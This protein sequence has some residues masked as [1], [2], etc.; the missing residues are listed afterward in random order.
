MRFGFTPVQTLSLENTGGDIST[1]CLTA[2]AESVAEL[3]QAAQAVS[4]ALATAQIKHYFEIYD[5]QD[6]CVS[7]ICW[8]PRHTLFEV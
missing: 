5:S 3:I 6:Q 1:P 7:V 4:A 8:P 2:D